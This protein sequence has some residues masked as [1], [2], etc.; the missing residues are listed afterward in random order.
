MKFITIFFFQ[1]LPPIDVA[2]DSDDDLSLP[3]PCRVNDIERLK[4]IEELFYDIVSSME[5]LDHQLETLPAATHA[6]CI[7]A[8]YCRVNSIA[9]KRHCYLKPTEQ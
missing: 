1:K 7:V 9:S 6:A 2:S 5:A 4:R 8:A 3:L